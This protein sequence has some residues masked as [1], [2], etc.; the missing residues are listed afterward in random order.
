[1]SENAGRIV[2]WLHGAFV[3]DCV[4]AVVAVLVTVIEMQDIEDRMGT[5]RQLLVEFCE[6]EREG[7]CA[8]FATPH[9]DARPTL[10]LVAKIWSERA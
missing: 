1:V 7:L 9:E 2:E 10:A 6:E 5:G 8:C 4:L 3:A